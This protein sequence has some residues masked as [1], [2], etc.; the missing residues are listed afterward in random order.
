[1]DVFHIRKDQKGVSM[2]K[3]NEINHIASQCWKYIFTEAKTKEPMI[4]LENI[5]RVDSLDYIESRNLK[6]TEREKEIYQA[7]ILY[8]VSHKDELVRV[9]WNPAKT[10]YDRLANRAEIIKL[11]LALNNC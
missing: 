11:E 6:L 7:C 2:N 9:Y 8:I 5:P 10:L 1:M 4:A 3:K